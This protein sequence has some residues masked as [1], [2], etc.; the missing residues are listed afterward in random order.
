M[1]NQTV[2]VTFTSSCCTYSL[3]LSHMT[4]L[5]NIRQTTR[6]LPLR[7]LNKGIRCTS[8]SRE[9]NFFGLPGPP[10][11]R[12]NWPST[13]RFQ[14]FLEG[15]SPLARNAGHDNH[16]T[17]MISWGFQTPWSKFA[18]IYRI[19]FLTLWLTPLPLYV[20][21]I[22]VW[23]PTVKTREKWASDNFSALSQPRIISL[24]AGYPA[25]DS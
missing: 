1:F 14:P 6:T 4:T 21:V 12:W 8:Y 5:I 25:G 24:L 18:I 16:M 23:F 19:T 13:R 17:S 11:V 10:D 9:R 20:D 3:F 22:F 15:G 2:H 7:Q